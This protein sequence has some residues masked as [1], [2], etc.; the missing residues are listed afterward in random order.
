MYK[1]K[2]VL[3]KIKL[4]LRNPR[5]IKYVFRK[6]I[7]TS[8]GIVLVIHE[9]KRLGASILLL[10]MA[11]ELVKQGENVYI[12]TNSFGEM[13]EE[14]SKIAPIQIALTNIGRRHILK[15]LSKNG[16]KK[17]I[18]NTAVC[19][20]FAKIGK[21]YGYVVISF[22]HELD[23]VIKLLHIEKKVK[24]MITYSD[25]TVFSTTVAKK[26]VFDMLNIDSGQA[27]IKPQGVYFEKPEQKIIDRNRKKFLRKY[28]QLGK[29]KVILGVGNTSKRK[30]YDIFVEVAKRI[31]DLNFV[32]VGKKEHY[33]NECLDK[34]NNEWP[35][36][37]IYM[38]EMNRDELSGIYEIADVLF[39][40]SRKDTL[41]SIIFE[42][43]LFGNP[44]VGARESGGIVDVV[45]ESNGLL[46]EHADINEFVLAISRIIDDEK[47]HFLKSNILRDKKSKN[48]FQ[49]YILFIRKE[50]EKLSDMKGAYN[51]KK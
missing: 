22:I 11:K 23:Y 28:P 34:N 3:A 12:V 42:A 44:V 6:K 15:Q 1:V 31:P 48:S 19:G 47:L 24:K 38:G 30:G 50:F 13:N 8:D 41:P 46:T 10:H 33:F 14:Y 51:E 17:L 21:Q 18:I 49:S 7:K 2:R 9:S 32:W 35:N 27:I 39:M 16:F 5:D 43:L 25:E 4:A 20:D 29:K 40:C 36:N 45:D 26:Q 37:F